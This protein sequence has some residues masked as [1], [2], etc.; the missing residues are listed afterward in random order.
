M[1]NKVKWVVNF[2]KKW[3]LPSP[4]QHHHNHTHTPLFLLGTGEKETQNL[5]KKVLDLTSDLLPVNEDEAS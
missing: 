4:P 1:L 2:V 3:D 5:L